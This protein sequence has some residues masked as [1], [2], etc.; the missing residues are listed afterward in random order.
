[1]PGDMAVTDPGPA[2]ELQDR[3]QGKEKKNK[4]KAEC[5]GYPISIF[6]IVVNEF[7]ERFSYYGM[8]GNEI[9]SA[10]R[11]WGFILQGFWRWF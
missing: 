4:H 5:C 9:K 8:R 11:T 2:D 6:F 7:C 10:M 1:M 3:E